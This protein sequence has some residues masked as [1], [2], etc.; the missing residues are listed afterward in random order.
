MSIDYARSAKS[1]LAW[2]AVNYLGVTLVYI[3]V[4]ALPLL[5][6]IQGLVGSML[7]NSIPISLA[8]Y[9]YLR[10]KIRIS[11]LW[12]LTIGVAWIL[13][14]EIIDRLPEGFLPFQDDE[15][16]AALSSGVAMIGLSIGVLQWLLLRTHFSRSLWWI[17]AS[18]LGLGLG[19]AVVLATDLMN[20]NGFLAGV[21]IVF[22]YSFFTGLVLTW[23]LNQQKQ[24]GPPRQRAS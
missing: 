12:I 16:V 14:F 15:S 5:M 9:I 2:M 7:I 21:V 18:A 10:R 3:S 11:P 24:S 1:L 13:L 22:T 4:M 8:Q 20:N 23:L 19:M 17:P 6:T